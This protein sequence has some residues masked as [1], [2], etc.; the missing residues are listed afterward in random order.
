MFDVE[1][2]CPF[3]WDKEKVEG[4]P[5]IRHGGCWCSLGLVGRA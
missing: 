4:R 3:C 2:S 5:E 1:S